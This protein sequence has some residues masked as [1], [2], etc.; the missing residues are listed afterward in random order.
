M[1]VGVVTVCHTYTEFVAGWAQS[2]RDL[3]TKPARIVVA[4]TNVF[5]VA[6]SAQGVIPW[7]VVRAEEPFTY[8]GYL[9][10]AIAACDTDWVAWIGVDDRYRPHALDGIDRPDADV[11]AFGLQYASGQQ[12]HPSRRSAGDVLQVR[13][14]FVPCGSP[15]RR[16]LWE[17]IP[18][19]PDLAPFEDWAFWVGAARQGARFDITG[20]IDVDYAQHSAQIVPPMEPTRTRIAEWARTLEA[21]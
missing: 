11:V 12:W 6:A 7:T 20:R 21:Q 17:R 2:V 4:A 14:N 18:F 10:R 19:Q 13:E 9:N 8:G 3:T 15:F 1:S 16:S 5:D